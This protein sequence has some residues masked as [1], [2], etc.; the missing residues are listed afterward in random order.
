MKFFDNN[1]RKITKKQFEQLSA[2]LEEF[3]DLGGIVHDVDS[4]QVISGNQRCR[5]LD[6]SRVQPIVTERFDPPTRAG[7]VA[8]GYIEWR[9]ERF[10]YR[11][12]R[13]TPEQCLAANIK[14]NLDGGSW[15]WNI[16]GNWDA[17]LLKG[18]GFDGDMLKDW[19]EQS[20]ALGEMLAA[21]DIFN[22]TLNPLMSNAQ[23]TDEE[24]RRKAEE[25]ANKFAK[26]GD[27]KVEVICPQCGEIFFIN[28]D[29]VK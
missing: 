22:P 16:L 24:I 17:D 25:L 28:K 11:A 1:P 13:W 6:L 20:I 5:A 15:D 8:T 10:S 29:E 12:V 14:A 4:D 19:Q 21:E 2:D 23:Y 26:P 18:V 3:G 9:G 27:D 7:T